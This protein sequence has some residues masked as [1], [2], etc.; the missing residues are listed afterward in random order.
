MYILFIRSRTIQKK[1]NMNFAMFYSILV[2]ASND[3]K[4]SVDNLWDDLNFSEKNIFINAYYF[5]SDETLP[6]WF[7]V[8]ALQEWQLENP[9]EDISYQIRQEILE[10]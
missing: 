6:K 2:L 7:R 1:D 8:E 4:M 10:Q 5:N 9:F 3:I